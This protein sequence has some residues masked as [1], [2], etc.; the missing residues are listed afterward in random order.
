[1]TISEENN[2]CDIC[3][4]ELWDDGTCPVCSSEE[5]EYF[6]PEEF[7]LEIGDGPNPF[8]NGMLKH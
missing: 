6:L 3:N 7:P 2:H 1:M 5:R 8:W 4:A